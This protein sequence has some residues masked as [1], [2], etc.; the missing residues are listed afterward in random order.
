MSAGC[1]CVVCK[2]LCLSGCDVRHTAS[3]NILSDRLISKN[4]VDKQVVFFFL[5]IFFLRRYLGFLRGG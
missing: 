3:G 1:G 5:T 4:K 2:V